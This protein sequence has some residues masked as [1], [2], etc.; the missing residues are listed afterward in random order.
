MFCISARKLV[1]NLCNKILAAYSF[2][3]ISHNLRDSD[4]MFSWEKWIGPNWFYA[5]H[6]TAASARK[7][8]AMTPRRVNYSLFT[9][10]GW[11][12]QHFSLS[13]GVLFKVW[14]LKR[15]YIFARSVRGLKSD[16]DLVVW[17]GPMHLATS[18]PHLSEG[19]DQPSYLVAAAG[20]L[21]HQV[22]LTKSVD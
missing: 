18:F 16:R 13:V 20:F 19:W 1:L 4:N 7:E 8:D 21:V 9:W 22:N 17:Q 14:P 3:K 11:Q 12:I 15:A 6:Y 10:G 5:V 2:C